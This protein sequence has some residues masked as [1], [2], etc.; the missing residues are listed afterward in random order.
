MVRCPSCLQT[1][2]HEFWAKVASEC[3]ERTGDEGP[4]R[5]EAN[6]VE[7]FARRLVSTLV[8]TAPSM[9]P[10]KLLR[11]MLLQEFDST[12]SERQLM[13]RLEYD[14]H[15]VDEILASIRS[16][17]PHVG[18]RCQQCRCSMPTLRARCY[19]RSR[20]PS[21][22]WAACFSIRQKG[23]MFLHRG[24]KIAEAKVICSTVPEIAGNRDICRIGGVRVYIQ[25]SAH[26]PPGREG[27]FN[28]I[29]GFPD[30][31]CSRMGLWSPMATTCCSTA[32]LAASGCRRV[33]SWFPHVRRQVAESAGETAR[34]TTKSSPRH[35]APPNEMMLKET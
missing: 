5:R 3:L 35:I 22:E 4:A 17:R 32:G 13:E 6:A 21:S 14:L 20:T 24:N 2:R 16:N 18:R 15:S 11:A 9:P 33:G 10:E 7:A 30:D 31:F 34:K 12:R 8:E 26:I 25:H 29:K 19:R 23:A 28:M 27:L 1:E